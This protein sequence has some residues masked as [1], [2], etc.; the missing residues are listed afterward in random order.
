MSNHQTS[1]T[2]TTQK[3]SN[4]SRLQV[5]KL[6]KFKNPFSQ[7]N[8][9]KK[10]HQQKGLTQFSKNSRFGPKL[11]ISK[12]QSKESNEEEVEI[13]EEM[14]SSAN[15]QK[16]RPSPIRFYKKGSETPDSCKNQITR[17]KSLSS[18]SSS[19]R[20]DFEIEIN[21]ESSSEISICSKEKKDLSQDIDNEMTREI[22]LNVI[23]ALSENEE[24]TRKDLREICLGGDKGSG[25]MRYYV[26]RKIE[27]FVFGNC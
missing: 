24:I 22:Y 4:F 11:K 26:Y 21:S 9:Q 16:K 7:F 3:L 8:S 20:G 5:P 18:S 15:C 17:L 25:F 6:T 2:S 13:F 1:L 14:S 19:E 10:S 27:M 23:N 12:I